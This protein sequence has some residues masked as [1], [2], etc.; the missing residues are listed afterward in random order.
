MP[1]NYRIFSCLDN[2]KHRP[3]FSRVSH[4]TECNQLVMCLCVC[5]YSQIHSGRE[6]GG[7]E[8]GEGGKAISKHLINMLISPF[9]SIHPADSCLQNWQQIRKLTKLQIKP[10]PGHVCRCAPPTIFVLNSCLWHFTNLS[11][12]LIC[13]NN[14]PDEIRTMKTWTM[15]DFKMW[16]LLH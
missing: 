4:W 9:C 1:F 5:L 10:D 7:K 13:S 16:G 12:H 15:N 8:G 2:L 3:S 14:Y 6:G 11:W